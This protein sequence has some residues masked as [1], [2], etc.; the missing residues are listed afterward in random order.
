MI[1][2]L[3]GLARGALSACVVAFLVTASELWWIRG[4]FSD[5]PSGL[6]LAA[7]LELV[8]G[9][10]GVQAF[11]AF[12]LA[13]L[14]C[15][16]AWFSRSRIGRV[17][18]WVACGLL[19]FLLNHDLVSRKPWVGLLLL[20]AMVAVPIG[21]RCARTPK[22]GWTRAMVGTLVVVGGVALVVNALLLRGTNLGQHQ[23]LILCTWLVWITAAWL[24]IW[25]RLMRAAGTRHV[26]LTWLCC[27]LWA[28]A[29]L[30]AWQISAGVSQ[31]D[32]RVRF[33]LRAGLPATSPTLAFFDH[34]SDVDGDGH[35]VWFG[36]GD[37]APWDAAVSPEGVEWPGDG[38]DGNCMAGD[39]DPAQVERLRAALAGDE[40]LGRGRRIDRIL[41]ITVDAL[42]HDSHL[43]RVWSKLGERCRAFSRAYATSHST[44]DSVYS[45][46]RSRFSSQ[47][48]FSRIG[49]FTM[50]MADPS[51]TLPEVLAAAG[52]DTA[53]V[54]FHHRFDPRMKLT[55]GFDHV[56]TAEARREI[57]QGIAAPSTIAEATR[58][59]A[60]ARP[61][62][63]LWVHF[64]D[65]HAPYLDHGEPVSTAR[66]AYDAEVA[67]TDAK[68][69]EFLDTLGD[70]LEHTAVVLTSDHGEA[71]GEHG[72]VLHANTL[73]EEELH[74]PLWV[75]SPDGSTGTVD[76]P[77]SGVDVAPTILEWADVER[78]S[79]FL[80]RSLLHP[81]QPVPVRAASGIEGLPMQALIVEHHKLIRHLPGNA[82]ALFD[83]ADDPGER[84]DLTR[85]ADEEVQGMQQLLDQFEA[86]LSTHPR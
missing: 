63:F 17:G 22:S 10:A 69:L 18:V 4:A 59:H 15:I 16:G 64:Y 41:L 60:R 74:V 50:P 61:P 49:D 42:R 14:V 85:F 44:T 72:T 13:P 86:V 36:G 80:G 55:R 51:P 39:P 11:V 47:G 19:L 12:M 57:I 45:L 75:C 8:S 56:W 5:G 24:A 67:F 23:T 76:T 3:L 28:A 21:Y 37:C 29:G 79:S 25:P 73:F 54:V 43:P 77:V 38:V 2:L 20:A 40:A 35:A 53:A 30:Y 82:Y 70:E 34:V 84:V 78:P 52:Y 31:M 66:E 65:V 83:L 46:L 32:P 6:D 81:L 1:E 27:G 48:E 7:R 71:F 68:I 62:W 33:S 9:I 26:R 58:W